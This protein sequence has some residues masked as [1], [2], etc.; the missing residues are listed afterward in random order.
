MLR[1][2]FIA[3]LGSALLV[4][5]LVGTKIT[6]FKAMA[7][8]GASMVPPP[9]VVTAATVS[10]EHWENTLLATGTLRPVQG[11][12]VAAEI[13]GKVTEI[14]FESGSTVEAGQ[15]LVVLDTRSEQ[16]QLRS[17]QA[18]LAL[19]RSNLARNRDLRRNQTI[20]PAELDAAE[21]QFEQAAAQ[22]ENIRTTIAKKSIRAPFAGRLGM[23]EVN[24]GEVLR[25][26]AAITSLQQ[27]HPIHVDFSLPQQYL[28]ELDT[29]TLLRVTS[30]AAPADLFEGT[31]TAIS[32][33]V[34][35]VTRNV[36][37][38]ATVANEA[39][40]LRGGMYAKVEVVL[41]TVDKLLTIPVTAVLHAPF[42]DSVFV[43]K[44]QPA[45]DGQPASLTLEQRFVRLGRSKGDFVSIVDGLDSG[46]RV[47]SSG[48]FKLRT[49]M[50]VEID[51]TLAPKARLAP[52]P[53][54]T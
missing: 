1:K 6:Q 36:L 41:P 37:L 43:I 22:V 47:A 32:P 24:L 21:A 45:K 17:A 14:A 42:G 34:D 13:G 54:D 20:S 3:L 38:Q 19:A 5:A 18:A 29:G 11:V 52:R 51:N 33:A 12:T 46:E 10:E 9:E 50:T 25:E 4:A 40:K 53:D 39:E 44:Q 35:A 31:I 15:V 8:A 30:D 27:L 28:P 23:R 49:G 48:V 16:T 2:I 7:E 26:G